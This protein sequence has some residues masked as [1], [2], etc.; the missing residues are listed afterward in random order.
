M[1][2]PKWLLINPI[3]KSYLSAGNTFPLN[4]LSNRTKSMITDL[5]YSILVAAPFII[6]CYIL[7]GLVTWQLNVQFGTAYL[8]FVSIIWVFLMFIVLNKDFVNCRSAG[9]RTY[10]FKIINYKTKEPATGLQCMLRNITA[11]IWPIEA[12]LIFM[13]PK[14]RLGDFIAGTQVIVE[15]PTEIEQLWNELNSSEGMNSKLIIVTL[16][17]SIALTAISLSPILIAWV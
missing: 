16:V 9:K 11:Y 4:I 5:W 2:I 15:E 6:L 12:L 7:Y 10:G 13:N 1:K 8:I 14:R 17:V 3:T